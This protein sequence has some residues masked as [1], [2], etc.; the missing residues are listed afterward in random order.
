LIEIKEKANTLERTNKLKEIKE[1]RV[2]ASPLQNKISLEIKN[3]D[4]LASKEELIEDLCSELK[5]SSSEGIDIKTIKM[6]LWD[7]QTAIVMVLAAYLPKEN[8]NLKIKAG[9]TIAT[10]RILPRIKKCYRCHLIGHT[11]SQ[12][13]MIS[14]GKELCRRRGARVHNMSNMS[15]VAACVRYTS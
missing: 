5:I 15:R 3:I 10:A 12:C 11:T 9:L 8:F 7:M 14:P 1:N 13:K 6:T 4:P 2:Q